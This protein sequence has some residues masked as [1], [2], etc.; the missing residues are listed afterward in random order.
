MNVEAAAVPIPVVRSPHHQNTPKV[1]DVFAEVPGAVIKTP[2]V[3]GDATF[4]FSTSA[5]FSQRKAAGN[6]AALREL[7]VKRGSTIV[8]E[9]S[10]RGFNTHSFLKIFG[11]M[12]RAQ[13][14]CHGSR[15]GSVVCPPGQGPRVRRMR[16]EQRT[17]EHAIRARRPHTGRRTS[18][19][20]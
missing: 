7:L 3:S 5:V 8:D 14:Q 6:R 17:D 20:T 11:G 1:A 10:C 13:A 16:A 4:I 9:F 15:P 18:R 2:Q 19:N 12:N